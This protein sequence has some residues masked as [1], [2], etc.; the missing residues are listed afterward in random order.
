MILTS[1]ALAAALLSQDIDGGVPRQADLEVGREVSYCQERTIDVAYAVVPAIRVEFTSVVI[2]GVPV[3][4]DDLRIMNSFLNMYG[5][6]EGLSARCR[7]DRFFLTVSGLMTTPMYE[8]YVGEQDG[9]RGNWTLRFG[10]TGNRLTDE[11]DT[12]Q[13]PA[14]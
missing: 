2:D 11:P 7:D 14:P 8:L 9:V 5:W 1:Y 6:L 10:F 4:E 12:P 13:R 3:S